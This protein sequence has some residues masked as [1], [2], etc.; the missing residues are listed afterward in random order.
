MKTIPLTKGF[1]ATVDDS[2]F[3]VLSKNKWCV[4]GREGKEYAV[5]HTGGSKNQLLYM[6]RDILNAPP[7]LQVDHINHNGLDN[8]R[9]NLRL[10]TNSQQHMNS[11]G[12]KG[13]SSKYKGV[14]REVLK[15]GSS[16]Q[17]YITVHGKNIRLGTF[18]T[19]EDAAIAYDHAARKYFGQ[20]AKPNFAELYSLPSPVRLTKP[21]VS[22]QKCDR[23]SRAR[24]LCTM[25]Y[26]AWLKDTNV[27]YRERQNHRKPRLDNALNIV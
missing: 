4:N 19:E 14:H 16:W 8:R 9:Q 7:D 11:Y 13:H 1:L 18:R 24:G 5:R 21:K 22:C 3:E 10:V 20:Y 27:G 2:D 26:V 6:H 25:H 17:A 23:P 12:R 15:W